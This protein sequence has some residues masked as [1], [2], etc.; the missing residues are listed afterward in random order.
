MSYSISSP[1]PEHA[2][3]IATMVHGIAL[4]T[5]GKNMD[6]ETMIPCHREIIKNQ[7]EDPENCSVFHLVAIDQDLNPV[8]LMMVTR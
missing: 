6:L 2:E 5:E 3:A 4:E 8:G 1:L 7:I